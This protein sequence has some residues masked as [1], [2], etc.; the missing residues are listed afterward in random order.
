MCAVLMVQLAQFC[1]A[2]RTIT[3]TLVGLSYM[4]MSRK[5]TC[6]CQVCA[7]KE[8]A[9]VLAKKSKLRCPVCQREA[10]RIVVK[11]AADDERVPALRRCKSAVIVREKLEEEIL[12]MRR[13]VVPAQRESSK[14]AVDRS[15]RDTQIEVV[16]CRYNAMSTIKKLLEKAQAVYRRKI[17]GQQEPSS[18]MVDKP[19]QSTQRSLTLLR[20]MKA[21]SSSKKLVD[22]ISEYCSAE[23]Q[24]HQETSSQ[25]VDKPRQNTQRRLTLHSYAAL[26][27][28]SKELSDAIFDSDGDEVQLQE[29]PLTQNVAKGRQNVQ[30][31]V[32]GLCEEAM[33][34]LEKPAEEL[35]GSC[36]AKDPCHRV[37][38]NRKVAEGK[39]NT[40]ADL[41]ECRFMEVLSAFVKLPDAI[42][43]STAVETPVQQASSNQTVVE[44]TWT[45]RQVPLLHRCDSATFSWDT[46]CPFCKTI[47]HIDHKTKCVSSRL[48]NYVV[49]QHLLQEAPLLLH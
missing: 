28:A 35:L 8:F 41:F 33:S 44:D 46:Q 17:P 43:A 4:L 38:V 48:T 39:Q 12:G 3:E 36:A 27:F 19:R 45:L 23:V 7:C 21:L 37:S 10:D 40:L 31:S 5:C 15:K 25:T 42:L 22:A 2:S 29:K 1:T 24:L 32:T 34:A 20:Y 11:D 30:T 14:H 9:K 26:L 13:V 47:Q 49:L 6:Y 16:V 18:R